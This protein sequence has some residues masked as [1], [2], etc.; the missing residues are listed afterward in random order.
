[1]K[2]NGDIRNLPNWKYFSWGILNGLLLGILIRHGVDISTGGI[3]STILE[4]FKPIFQGVNISTL[5]IDISVFLLAAVGIAS[6][7]FEMILIWN[8]GWIARIITLFG[9]TSFFLLILGLDTIGIIIF[10]IGILSVIILPQIYKN[11][12]KRR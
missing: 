4:A 7:V 3:F 11:Q 8:K 5:W 12:P 10:V 2:N 6:L 1:M 9:F